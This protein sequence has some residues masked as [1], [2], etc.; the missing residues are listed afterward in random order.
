MVWI[1]LFYEIIL[2][3]LLDFSYHINKIKNKTSVFSFLWNADKWSLWRACRTTSKSRETAKNISFKL[4]TFLPYHLNFHLYM[5]ISMQDFYLNKLQHIV[6][7]PEC[8]NF[9]YHNNKKYNIFLVYFKA[10]V[11]YFSMELTGFAVGMFLED[12]RNNF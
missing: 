4:I 3:W 11:N 10:L 1:L 9:R 7:K 5:L 8:V 12:E 2:L 6:S